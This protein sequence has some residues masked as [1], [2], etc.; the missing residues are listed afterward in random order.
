MRNSTRCPFFGSLLLGAI[1]FLWTDN[2]MPCSVVIAPTPLWRSKRVNVPRILSTPFPCQANVKLSG[3]EQSGR[4]E[5]AKLPPTTVWVERT[6]SIHL[7]R[8]KR[9]SEYLRGAG[10]AS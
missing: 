5:E 1:E 3:R 10:P 6:T 9:G 8:I 4:E 7:L 2:S